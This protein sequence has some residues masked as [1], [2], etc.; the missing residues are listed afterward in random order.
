MR[1]FLKSVEIVLAD[2]DT[3]ISLP[4]NGDVA[5]EDKLTSSSVVSKTR[6]AR[7]SV[8]P[9]AHLP[10]SEQLEQKK[11]SL[12][13]NLKK[14]T[15][16]AHKACPDVVSFPEWIHKLKAIELREDELRPR[17]DNTWDPPF[18]RA[19]NLLKLESSKKVKALDTIEEVLVTDAFEESS[20]SLLRK[21]I[22]NLLRKFIRII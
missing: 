12:E 2:E 13:Q 21:C 20:N 11:K 7:D 16:N 10:Y 8:S 1:W 9:L 14:L 6:S 4:F 18:E 22:T 5:L 3:S 17:P 19:K 15:R